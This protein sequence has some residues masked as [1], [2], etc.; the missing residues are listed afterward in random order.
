M[1]KVGRPPIYDHDEHPRAARL[2]A[3]NMKTLS[4]MAEVFG[5]DRHTVGEW[6]VDHPEF[7]AAIALGKQ[8]AV[9]AVEQAL[10]RRATGYEHPAV[11]I[12]AV[13][14]GQ[15]MPASIEQVPYTEHY[16]PDTEALKFILKNK[17][18]A[19]WREKQEVE[20]SGKMTLEQI[21]AGS[22]EETKTEERKPEGQQ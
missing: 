18:P 7:A 9:D 10:F 14:Q 16:P 3:A 1:A 19:E 5:V 2:M 11:K 22:M 4:E 6:K 13:S 8:D 12:M 17:K 21:L 15:G 20:H